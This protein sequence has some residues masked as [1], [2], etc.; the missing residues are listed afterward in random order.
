[1]DQRISRL[2][3]L[4][5]AC[6]AGPALASEAVMDA[7][8]E[9]SGGSTTHLVALWKRPTVLF[10][11]DKDS[12]AVNQHVKDALYEQGRSRG[13][14]DTVAVVAVANVA[15]FDWFPARDFVLAAVRDVER[16]V[17]VPVY[18]D[19]KGQLAAPPWSL[20][21]KSSTVLVLSANG[22]VVWRAQGRLSERQVDALFEAL[23]RQL[24][25]GR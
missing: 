24:R 3:V 23:E 5:A 10:Y 11:E 6:L 8:V 25:D 2:A 1:M 22:E 18:L 7:V 15:A 14:L 16:K 20:A 19:F 4:L 12:T 9:T 13:L 17:H 21:S